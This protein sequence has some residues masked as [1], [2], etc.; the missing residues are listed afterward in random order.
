MLELVINFF[1]E[2]TILVLKIASVALYTL[3]LLNSDK[4]WC[5]TTGMDLF[6]TTLARTRMLQSVAIN[7]L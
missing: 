5:L 6:Q 1:N 4:G 3:N 2:C 7:D